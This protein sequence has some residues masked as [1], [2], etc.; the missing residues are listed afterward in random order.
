M[1]L[2][3][4]LAKITCLMA[5]TGLSPSDVLSLQ[6]PVKA[7]SIVK[8]GLLIQDNNS[9]AAKYGAEMA[10]RKA[11]ETGGINGEKIQLIVKSMEG[12]WGTGSKQAVDLIFQENVCAL[13]GSHDGRNAHLVEQVSAKARIVFLSAWA[14]DPTLSQAFVPW[15]FSCIPNDLQQADAFINE[16]YIKRKLTRIAAVAD[17]GYDSKLAL[18]S[19]IKKIKA[20]DQIEPLQFFYDNPVQ[21]FAEILNKINKS[22]TQCII[23]I[24]KPSA[25]LKF[26]QEKEKRKMQQTIFG[27]MS[28]LDEDES[29]MQEQEEF[30]NMVLFVSG[31]W[32]GPKGIAFRKEYQAQYGNVPGAVAAYSFDGMNLLIEAIRKAGTDRNEIQKNLAKIRY[33][34]VTGLIQFDDKGKRMGKV[35][36]VEIKNGISIPIEK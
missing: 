12:P 19:L 30:R 10:I 3:N 23:L 18:S 16:I 33:N 21:D 27:A 13:L 17:N 1:K 28:V 5:F 20:S 4:L 32:T 24:G 22:A 29:S 11:N 31:N 34:G 7:D 9:L 25:S 36:M 26:I 6:I 35:N 14:S 8:I 15:F 2:A